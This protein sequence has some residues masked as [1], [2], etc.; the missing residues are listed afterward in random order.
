MRRTFVSLMLFCVAAFAVSPANACCSY[1]CCDCSCVGIVSQEQ[2]EKLAAS[3]KD[4]CARLG[5]Q[6]SSVDLVVNTDENKVIA[7]SLKDGAT[8]VAKPGKKDSGN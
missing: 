5:I 4:A 8:E 7:I 6:A 2:A 1:G 3:V